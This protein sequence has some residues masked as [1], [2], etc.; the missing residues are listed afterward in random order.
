MQAQLTRLNL[1]GQITRAIGEH[2]DTH[3]IFAVVTQALEE[4][5]AVD[6]CCICLYD[7][8]ARQLTVASVGSHSAPLA[9][10]LGLTQQARIEIDENGLSRCVRGELVHEPDVRSVPFP[11]PTR[12]AKGGLCSLVVAPLLVEPPVFGIL[13][14]ARREARSFSSSDCEFLRQVSEHVALAAHQAQLHEALQRAYDDLRHTQQAILQQERLLALG[15]M[16]SGIAHDIN[17]A[18]SPIALYTDALL[19][20]AAELT[21]KTRRQVEIIR[22]AIDDVAQTVARL[23]E[24]YRAR[25]AQQTQVPVDLNLLVPQV[26]D[27]TRARWSDMA[28]RRGAVIEVRCDLAPDLP[29][30]L[31]IEGELRDALTNLIFNAVDAMPTGGQ[32]AVRTLVKD[33]DAVALDTATATGSIQLEVAD[34]GV[35]MDEDTLR[36]CLEPFFTTKGERG[37]GLGLALVYGTLQRHGGDIDIQSSPG[38]GTVVRLSFTIPKDLGGQTPVA[39]PAT[40]TESLHILLIDDDPLVLE[41]MRD[42]LEKEGH[43]VTLADGGQ[44]GIDAFRRAIDAGEPIPVVI[45]DLGMPYV[46]GRAV[47]RAIKLAAPETRVVLLTGWGQRLAED[48]DIPQHVDRVLSKPPRLRELREALA[49]P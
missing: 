33:A 48:G 10:E 2:Q 5:L 14:A 19:E 25:E 9:A 27:L 4:H 24:F 11:F 42:A 44:A 21:P 37:T 47:S 18:I 22:R 35:G 20:H 15:K 40:V 45:T 49:R 17:N 6:F 31:G 39:Q 30:I 26:I 8:T 34:T 16:A 12:L 28:Q 41:S 23:R 36:R 38:K 3:R 1:L 46:D 7:E 29:A 13:V 32:L 43:R